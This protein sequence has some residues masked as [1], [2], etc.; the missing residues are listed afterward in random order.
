VKATLWS[1]LACG[2]VGLALAPAPAVAAPVL[3]ANCP[4]D[5]SANLPPQNGDYRFGQTF[6]AQTTGSL[7][8]GQFR[9]EKAGSPGDYR[10]DL[11]ATDGSGAP[12]NTM[13][14]ST[15]IPDASVPAGVS[16]ITGVFASPAQV[17]AG[18]QYA[19]VITRPGSSTLTVAT[20]MG[21]P[22]PGGGEFFSFGQAEAWFQQPD[23]LVFATFVEPG[24]TTPP[25]AQITKG[26]K[27]KTRKRTATFEFTGTDARAISSFECKL[28][29]GAFAPCTSPHKVKV[30]KGRHTFEVRA[31]DQ[32]GNVGSPE[33]DSWKRKK[34][35]R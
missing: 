21:N 13:L 30:K 3:D 24:D 29:Q 27:D 12:T 9:I 32:A 23:D 2:L 1:A 25:Q 22:C 14:A 8:M 18:Q 19:L 16:T 6:T 7:A 11:N 20:R 17:T 33:T 28:D 26:P 15:T 35:K 10:M 34:K 31:I 5:P 4:D